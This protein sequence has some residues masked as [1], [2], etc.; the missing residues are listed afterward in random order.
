MVTHLVEEAAELADKIIVM[1]PRPGRIRKIIIDDL[2][3]P[4]D[5]RSRAFFKLVDEVEGLL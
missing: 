2:P 4:R 1:S 5:V 3:R